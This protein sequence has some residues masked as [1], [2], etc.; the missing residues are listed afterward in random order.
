MHRAVCVFSS[1]LA[2]AIYFQETD[3]IFPN[4]GGLMF[5]W[6][7][8]SEL[9]LS[10]K[11]KVFELLESLGGN[12]RKLKRS[13]KS[14]NSQFEFKVSMSVDRDLLV[15]QAAFGKAFGTVT[16]GIRTPGR[17]EALRARMRE[18]TGKDGPFTMLQPNSEVG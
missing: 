4:D 18:Q 3:S 15:I 10:G 11:Y 9:V 2:K 13:G 16:F 7:S 12:V 17:L 1:K 6:F 8:N 5:N 14:L